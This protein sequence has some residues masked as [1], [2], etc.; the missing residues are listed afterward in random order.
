MCALIHTHRLFLLHGQAYQCWTGFMPRQ[1]LKVPKCPWKRKSLPSHL[2]HL[3]SLLFPLLFV[4]RDL[5][6]FSQRC[7]KSTPVIAKHFYLLNWEERKKKM[8][9]SGKKPQNF[10][11][12]FSPLLSGRSI[13]LRALGPIRRLITTWSKGCCSTRSNC[14]TFG[15]VLRHG[16]THMLTL[17]HRNTWI[18]SRGQLGFMCTD[19]RI[20]RQTLL[21]IIYVFIS[22]NV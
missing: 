21:F 17:A 9:W 7:P 13:G 1:R 8:R 4:G 19:R 20:S 12:C 16:H 5:F 14:S 2:Y 3:S 6:F 22:L 11:E 18:V 10:F 15:T